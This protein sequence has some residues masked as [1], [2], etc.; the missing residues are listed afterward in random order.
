MLEV[1]R[2]FWTRQALRAAY[3]LVM[4]WLGASVAL[5]FIPKANVKARPGD[6]CLVLPRW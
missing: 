1:K 4:V 6:K 3:S 5:A 2:I